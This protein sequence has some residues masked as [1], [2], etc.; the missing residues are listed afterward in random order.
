MQTNDKPKRKSNGHRLP[1]I[2]SREDAGAL[3]KA[4][5]PRYPTG[6]RN[7]AILYVLYRAGL[8]ESEVCNLALEDVN[9]DQGFIFVQLGKRKKDRVVPM[10]EETIEWCRRW[11][12]RRPP[13]EWFFCTLKGSRLSERYIRAMVARMSKRA[14]VY[15]RDGRE[16]KLVHPHTLRHCFVTELPEDGLTIHE[17]AEAA[18]HASITTTAKYLHVRPEQLAAKLR[19]R[20]GV[21]R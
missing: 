3:L 16:K 2:I 9:L 6:L 4:P 19:N 7:R 18:G 17:A 15:L 12:D 14:G 21:G 13:S 10:D 5:N 1:K 11:L 8:R 20:P